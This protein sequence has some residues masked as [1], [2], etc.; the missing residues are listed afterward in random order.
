MKT[1]KDKTAV[2]TG[3]G[4]G[5]G[6]AIALALAAAGAH[7]VVADIQHTTALAVAEEA[8][9][10]GVNA[11]AIQCDVS[12]PE[13]VANLSSQAFA[14]FGAVHILCNNAGVSWRP[15]RSILDA[16][17]EDFQFIL[18]I[19]LWGVLHGLNAFL[20]R[21]RLQIG[22]KH[23]VNT[24]SL[25]GLFPHEG[26]A[27]YSTSKG[28]V[29]NLSE[30]IARELAQYDFGVTIL[31]PGAVETNLGTNTVLLHGEVPFDDRQRFAPVARPTAERMGTFG[32]P[33]AE[34]V[35][36]MVLNAI[37]ENTLYLHTNPLPYDM[38]AERIHTLFGPQ[39]V[40][41]T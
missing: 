25:A 1:V 10:R 34:P 17:L 2:V 15:H 6:R 4:S 24:A 27:P 40:G 26:H 22:E 31:C 8:R 29:V 12:K 20:P 14:E 30:V 16:T 23:I 5:I 13:S 3:A 7:V 39:T 28:A 21:M 36:V 18:G 11:V 9:S 35:G 37:L 33:S 19:N 38:V 41:R 32:L